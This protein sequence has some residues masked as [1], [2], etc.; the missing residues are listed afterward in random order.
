MT[1][2]FLDANVILRHLLGDHDELSR[3]ATEVLATVE[4]GELRVRV[5]DSVIAEVVFTLGRHYGKSKAV[6][7]DGLIPLLQLSGVVVDDWE[8]SKRTLDIYVERNIPFGDAQIVGRMESERSSEVISF[9][10]D[11]DR[12]PGIT[13]I[14]P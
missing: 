4:R 1:L 2:P 11:F 12:I 7:Y 9:D 8:R 3:R 6:I 10:R 14:E 5:P 13:R